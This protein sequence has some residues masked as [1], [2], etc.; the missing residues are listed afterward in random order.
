MRNQT[1]CVVL[2]LTLAGGLLCAK[3]SHASGISTA[4]FGAEH[5]TPVSANPTAVYYNPAALAFSEHSYEVYFDVN[6]ALRSA[7]YQHTAAPTDEAEPAGAQGAN[8]D[9]AKLFNVLAV[10]MFGASAKFGN[11]AVGAGVYVPFGG[12]SIWTKNDRF[13]DSPYPGLVDSGARWYSINGTIQSTYYTAAAA[14][15]IGNTGLSLGLSGNLV[16]SVVHTIRARTPNGTNSILSEGRSYTDTSGWHGSFGIGALYEAMKDKLWL[17]ASYQAQPG[18][19]GKIKLTGKL[20]GSFAGTES[21]T[22][23]RIDEALPDVIRV[24]V[25]YRVKPTWELR[26][27]GDY[28][29][30]SVFEDQCLGAEDKPCAVDASGAASAGSG[31]IQNLPRHWND[32]FGVRVGTSVWPSDPLELMLGLGYDSNAIPD[33][34]LDPALVDFHD[35]MVALGARY[36]LLGHIFGGI[37]ATQFVNFPRDTGG[38]SGNAA[39]QMPSRGPD[40]GGKYTLSTTVINANM[41][42]AF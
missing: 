4:R 42:F 27:F 8:T 18:V 29:R 21:E 33:A 12:T 23:V 6:V 31:V 26:L 3:I 37:T 25:R 35:A 9:K 13:K 28:T 41:M 1:R 10:P 22:A 7:S 40:A 17:G 5:G 15:R 16:N 34:A 24:G 20:K 2:A 39:W 38:K 30:W 14:Y 11:L 36:R 19:S 32:A